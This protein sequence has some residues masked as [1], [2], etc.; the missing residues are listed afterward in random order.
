MEEQLNFTLR[1]RRILQPMMRMKTGSAWKSSNS[2]G[3]RTPTTRMSAIVCGF[4]RWPLRAWGDDV[5]HVIGEHLFVLWLERRNVGTKGR[6]GEGRLGWRQGR[7][8]RRGRGRRERPPRLN[9]RFDV[10]IEDAGHFDIEL[11]ERQR[12]SQSEVVIP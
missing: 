11:I 6:G 4:S 10:A 5:V 8:G 12:H 3:R 2:S 7:R 1:R 9:I